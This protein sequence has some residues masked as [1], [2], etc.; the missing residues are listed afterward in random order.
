MSYRHPR[1]HNQ[2]TLLEPIE[3]MAVFFGLIGLA[4]GA[5]AIAGAANS[6][7]PVPRSGKFCPLGY[8]YTSAYCVP[9]K[10]TK[11]QAFP[12]ENNSCPIGSYTRATY[13]VLPEL[14]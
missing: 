1:Y 14:H 10:T 13:C 7:T 2:K 4:I 6:A 5:L 9:T 11:T 12:R 8:Y 3:A